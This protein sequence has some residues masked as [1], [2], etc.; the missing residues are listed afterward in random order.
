M[1]IVISY[2]LL[3]QMTGRF[4]T[5]VLNLKL[6]QQHR[7][8]F[9]PLANC[10]LSAFRILLSLRLLRYDY[11]FPLSFVEA[12]FDQSAGGSASPP[13][14]QFIYED[15]R[16]KREY[17][18]FPS[19]KG[20]RAVRSTTSLL[21]VNVDSIKDDITSQPKDLNIEKSKYFKMKTNLFK[22]NPP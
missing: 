21:G 11:Q 15:R 22:D 7:M 14:H 20:G 16:I 3:F 1:L 13:A 12:L 10:V 19:E 17:S 18:L 4:T 9:F 6:L 5:V 8:C 2:L